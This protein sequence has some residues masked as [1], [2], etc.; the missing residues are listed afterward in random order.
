MKK[1]MIAFAALSILATAPAF[2]DGDVKKGKKVFKKCKAC[3]A[4]GEGAKAKVG[5][6]LNNIFG[7]TAGTQEGFKYSKVII[8]KGAEGLVWNAETMAEFFKG[9]KRFM[10]GTKMTFAG[11]LKKKDMEKE[12]KVKKAEK[13]IEDLLAYLKT[14]SPDAE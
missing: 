7:M 11:L 13:K 8:A 12:K 3:H 6:G 9:P 5:P 4:V 10:K 2:A 14:L 1:V